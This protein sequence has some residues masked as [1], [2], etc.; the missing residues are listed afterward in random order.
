MATSYQRNTENVG[1]ESNFINFVERTTF[2][3]N[4]R[5]EVAQNELISSKV[6]IST[7]EKVGNFDSRYALACLFASFC[8]NVDRNKN[9]VALPKLSSEGTSRRVL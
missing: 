8:G 5:I 2:V 7:D 3:M 9:A 1:E 4:Q 6:D